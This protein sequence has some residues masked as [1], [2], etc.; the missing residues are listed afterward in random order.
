MRDQQQFWI[1]E[2]EG[3]LAGGLGPGD[4]WDNLGD[5][6]Q[7]LILIPDPNGVTQVA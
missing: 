4:R 7:I 2:G 1:G 6:G 3:G 5:L